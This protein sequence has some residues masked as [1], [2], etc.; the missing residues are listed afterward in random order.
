MVEN[1]EAVVSVLQG[2][3]HE[4]R[5]IQVSEKQQTISVLLERPYPVHSGLLAPVGEIPCTEFIQKKFD[6]KE[7]IK[8]RSIGYVKTNC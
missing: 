1:E 2:Y 4:S 5:N 3:K 7:N 6:L 8:E